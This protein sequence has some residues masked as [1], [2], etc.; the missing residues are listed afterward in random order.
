MTALHRRALLDTSALIDF[1]PDVVAAIADE[2]SVSTI[3]IGE[4]YYGINTSRD[5][6]ERLRR[7]TR[8]STVSLL[9]DIRD[10]DEAAAEVYGALA[11]LV[12][13]YGRDPRPRRLDLQIA[14]VAASNRLPLLTRNAGD[15]AGLETALP[16]I[17]LR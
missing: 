4:L 3:T 1:E 5:A 7:Q 9:F 16:V 13:Q 8:A 10:F 14:A 11:D 2:V 15:F 12:R 6:V 17:G